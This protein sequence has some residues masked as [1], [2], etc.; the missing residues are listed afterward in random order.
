MELDG[1]RIDAGDIYLT[2]QWFEHITGIFGLDLVYIVYCDNPTQFQSHNQ[3]V[4]G[5][6]QITQVSVRHH[7]SL[8][9]AMNY[10]GN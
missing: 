4:Y 3:I 7:Q 9:M 2:I 10:N 8:Y 5:N 6:I 1:I